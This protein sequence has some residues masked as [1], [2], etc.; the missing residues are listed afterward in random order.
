MMQPTAGPAMQQAPVAIG[1][2]VLLAHSALARQ[3]PPSAM[4]AAWDRTEQTLLMQHA[5]PASDPQGEGVHRLLRP[6]HWPWA[7]AQTASVNSS[8]RTAPAAVMQQAPVPTSWAS[9]RAA[10]IS[11]NEVHSAAALTCRNQRPKELMLMPKPP[12]G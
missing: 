5:P 10:P 6:R 1:A 4:Q 2:Q 8:Q 3:V 11:A 12:R 9:V 7:V